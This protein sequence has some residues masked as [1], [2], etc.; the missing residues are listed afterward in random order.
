[1]TDF[2]KIASI[3]EAEPQ[4]GEH[5]FYSH[6][7]GFRENIV[8]AL[9]FLL[10]SMFPSYVKLNFED[11]GCL[12]G[13]IQYL[14]NGYGY[15]LAA[16]RM[17]TG[18]D[19][20]AEK[21]AGD[22]LQ[23]LPEIYRLLKKDVIAGYEGDPACKTVDEVILAYPAFIA[24]GTYRIA[25]VLYRLGQPVIA[26]IM[27][28]YAHRKTGIDIHPG[29]RIGESFFID[30]GTGVVIGETTVIGNHVKLYQHVTLGARSFPVNDDG[31]LVKGIKRHP[32]VGNNV[33][34]YAGAT[35]L[36]G[37]VYIGDNCVIGG[38]VWLTHSVEP[39][40]TVVQKQG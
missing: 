20:Q 32:N 19:G 29:A 39:G 16:L 17:T 10:D 21:L 9:L 12:N 23:E 13:R 34:I 33:V 2:E 30:H 22:V 3:L 24:I 40:I 14:K 8:K 7:E 25:H 35:I 11:V 38:N 37:D 36:G 6:Y 18:A 27:S 4:E 31:T 1:M 28:E 15:I 5:N 26:R